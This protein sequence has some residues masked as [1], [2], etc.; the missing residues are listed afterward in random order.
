MARQLRADFAGALH[1][2]YNRGLDGRDIFHDD[3]DR[4]FFLFWLGQMVAKF[5][6]VVHAYTLMTNHFH[7]L[8]ETPEGHLSKGMQQLLTNYVQRFNQKLDGNA[9]SRSKKRRRR[10]GPL[11]EG[12][13]KCWRSRRSVE[14]WT[15]SSGGAVVEGS[16]WLEKWRRA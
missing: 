7:L 9:M 1:H 6:W 12:R 16:A 8:I 10:H 14:F 15:D 13:F 5:G 4:L 11:L 3:G 2:V